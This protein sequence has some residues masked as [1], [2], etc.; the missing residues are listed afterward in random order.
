M[1]QPKQ[2]RS[3]IAYGLLALF[4]VRGFAAQSTASNGFVFI[5]P[6]PVAPTALLIGSPFGINTQNDAE[7]WPA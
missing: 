2:L 6:A 5:V 3:L 4:A 1:N 7:L